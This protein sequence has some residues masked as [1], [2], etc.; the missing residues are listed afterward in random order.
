MTISDFREPTAQPVSFQLCSC[1]LCLLANPID[2]RLSWCGKTIGRRR[3]ILEMLHNKQVW[4]SS[5]ATA[6]P[7][8][9]IPLRL[10]LPSECCT[11]S[12]LRKRVASQSSSS[13][14]F[15]TNR[16]VFDS[17]KHA[18]TRPPPD[19]TRRHSP[20][21]TA[22]SLVRIPLLLRLPS[23]CW[24]CSLLRKRVASES[25]RS[26]EFATE[27]PASFQLCSCPHCLLAKAP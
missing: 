25:S 10:R 6:C 27:H 12:L 23:D 17:S 13:G 15:A 22:C 4:L 8:V 26:G 14:E 7:L 5:A 1:P 16:P 21:A 2:L 20:A 3:S 11:F 9:R 19:H 18:A 24:T